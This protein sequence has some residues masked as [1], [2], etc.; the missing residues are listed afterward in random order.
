MRWMKGW[1]GLGVL[2]IAVAAAGACGDRSP[3]APEVPSVVVATGPQV[4]RITYAG[5]CPGGERPL[6]LLLYTPVTVTRDGSE[7]IARASSPEA[8]S[9]ELRFRQSRPM[10]IANS[11]AV[12]GTIKGVAAHV[13]GLAPGP[14]MANAR[15]DFGSDGAS[16]IEGFA[17][18]PSALTPVGGVSG[19]GSGAIRATDSDGRTCAGPTFSW[20]LGVQP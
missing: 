20:G 1:R 16:A 18:A 4:L 12:H 3:T 9:V 8:G 6:F 14:P 13:A 10:V 15:V 17:F 19:I 7:W 2:A 11:M 5:Q